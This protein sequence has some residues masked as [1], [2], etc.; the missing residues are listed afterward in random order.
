MSDAWKY[1]TIPKL[2]QR[3]GVTPASV[4]Q[5]ISQ[6]LIEA[7]PTLP[8]TGERA[9]GAAAAERIEHWYVERAAHGG[10]RGPGASRRRSWA[11]ERL[12]GAEGRP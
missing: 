6:G 2:A 3:L 4:R 12:S 11:Q 7:P 8:V 1:Y 10:T 5:W 9:F